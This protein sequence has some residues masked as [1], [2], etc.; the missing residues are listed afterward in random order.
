MVKRH[1][2]IADIDVAYTV[3]T[4]HED[5][6]KVKL[7]SIEKLYVAGGDIRRFDVEANKLVVSIRKYGV[8]EPIHTYA[9][10]GKY[11]IIDGQRRFI[12][13]NKLGL[14]EVPC[15]VHAEVR[16]DEEAFEYSFSYDILARNPHRLDKARAIRRMIE[17]E[18]S[19]EAVHAKYGIP[20]SVLS[21]WDSFNRLDLEV[22]DLVRS[23]GELRRGKLG[24]PFKWA[25][26]IARLPRDM[27]LGK[28]RDIIGLNEDEKIRRV[29]R[30]EKPPPGKIRFW[31][32]PV[33]EYVDLDP[34]LLKAYEDFRAEGFRGNLG[35][36]FLECI[37]TLAKIQGW[38]PP[39]LREGVRTDKTIAT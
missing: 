9:R 29:L 6:F 10:D 25:R 31:I 3:A 28:A 4:L 36:F 24:I 16:N 11:A 27:Q 19:V 15:V 18:G 13:A 20:K 38:I 26:E 23:P 35:E 12:A 2:L 22:Q 37:E 5:T 21:Q 7:V 8:K 32:K 39:S 14:R 34:L 17:K 1:I 30:E 33:I